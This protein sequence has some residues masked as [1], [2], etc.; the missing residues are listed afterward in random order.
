[1][2]ARTDGTT[3]AGGVASCLLDLFANDTCIPAQLLVL[4]APEH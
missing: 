2:L 3:C 4:L 1:M